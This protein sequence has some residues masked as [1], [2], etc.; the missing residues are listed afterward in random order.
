MDQVVDE[1][2]ARIEGHAPHAALGF[3]AHMPDSPDGA[4]FFEG[5]QNVSGGRVSPRRRV[6]LPRPRYG[7][8]DLLK[9]FFH[10]QVYTE[11]IS[12]G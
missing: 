10:V 4:S 9:H 11:P 3:G 7:R 12:H 1:I 2:L 5:G 8:V 6:T